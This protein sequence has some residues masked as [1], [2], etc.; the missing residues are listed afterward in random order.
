MNRSE[1]GHVLEEIHALH[2]RVVAV[3]QYA[4]SLFTPTD[5]PIA[6]ADENRLG[7]ALS[8]AISD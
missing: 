3:P 8:A 6:S 4:S 2:L 5:Q 7:S 1:L